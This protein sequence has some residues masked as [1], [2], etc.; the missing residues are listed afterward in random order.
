MRPSV[1]QGIT[2]FKR[3]LIKTMASKIQPW[4]NKFPASSL[5][6]TPYYIQ[7]FLVSET[8]PQVSFLEKKVR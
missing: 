5:S 2:T 6:L 4:Y 8:T 7:C 3:T 1:I